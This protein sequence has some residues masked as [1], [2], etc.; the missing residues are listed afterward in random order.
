MSATL[1]SGAVSI[2]NRHL[3]NRLSGGATQARVHMQ[4]SQAWTGQG[5]S[6]GCGRPFLGLSTAFQTG[7]S[8]AGSPQLWPH[9]K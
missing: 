7:D 6:Q 4:P 2:L 9:F 8:A 1:D 3:R 5:A